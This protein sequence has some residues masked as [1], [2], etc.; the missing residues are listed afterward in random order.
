MPVQCID[1]EISDREIAS[2]DVAHLHTA[3]ALTCEE[4]RAAFVGRPLARGIALA[5]FNRV[6]LERLSPCVRIVVTPFDRVWTVS[7]AP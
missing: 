5:R 7:G 4:V 1:G 3:V 6:Q 2:W